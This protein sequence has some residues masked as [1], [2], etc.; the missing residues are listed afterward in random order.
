MI[1]WNFIKS[2]YQWFCNLSIRYKMIAQ[3]LWGVFFLLVVGVAGYLNMEDMGDTSEEM[4]NE[5]LLP[6]QWFDKVEVDLHQMEADM[7]RLMLT[8]DRQEKDRIMVD[9]RDKKLEID[10]LLY[11]YRAK[12]TDPE[13][14][15]KL[16]SFQSQLIAYH[17][18]RQKIIDKAVG[19]QKE[20]AFQYYKATENQLIQI[21]KTIDE[22]SLHN[23]TVAERLYQENEAKRSYAHIM[24]LVTIILAILTNTSIGISISQMII[25]PLRLL[26]KDMEQVGRGNL[27]IHIE[28]VHEDEVG[29]LSKTLENTVAKL[30]H[31]IR[32][33]GETSQ[34]VY[35]LSQ[36]LSQEVQHTGASAEQISITISEVA[37]G[38]MTQ[39]EQA[40]VI[41]SMMK[42]S[43]EQVQEGN[44]Q[45]EN[46]L[47]KAAQSTRVAHKGQEAMTEA[48]EHLRIVDANVTEATRSIRYLGQKSDEI[49][50]ISHLITEIADQTNL[51]ALN[52]A[53]EAARA[54]EHGKGFAVVAD[55][56]RKL[57]EQSRDA[58]HQITQL[59]K[60]V[61]DNTTKTV[62]AMEENVAA[63]D[64][65]VSLIQ[66]GGEALKHIVANVESTEADAHQIREVF[67][68]LKSNST[69]V[70]RS[71]E[72]ISAIIEQSAA[73]TEEV[74]A[75]ADEQ[76]KTVE[77]MAEQAK[78]LDKLAAQLQGEVEQFTL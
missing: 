61:Q 52:A 14:E 59:I 58:A 41:L 48:V 13:I 8:D 60:D 2:M 3:M 74:S 62:N 77:E 54:G 22:L 70:L 33:V 36:R 53:I 38:T 44:W 46:T 51:L 7:V 27:N 34:H 10:K 15:E 29:E 25:K 17:R 4:Y 65:Q 66:N 49:G 21:N 1:L 12:N 78:K 32:Q 35:G 64:R 40:N 16:N 63:F 68:G 39:A 23:Q 71:I 28:T 76:S 5:R 43:V 31:L 24:I 55:E 75:S 6:I 19:R 30:R 69:Q 42:E 37:S 47:A 18:E 50:N 11:D 26:Q 57:A 67:N 45:A 20:D 9:V 73:S 56:V 72:E